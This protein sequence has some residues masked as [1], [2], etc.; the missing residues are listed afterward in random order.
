MFRCTFSLESVWIL[1]RF[2]VNNKV[3]Y[4]ELYR[5]C[6]FSLASPPT[7]LPLTI[8]KK[9]KN[10]S[11]KS[12]VFWTKQLHVGVEPSK[13]SQ[14][15]MGTTPQ[16]FHTIPTCTSCKDGVNVL[17]YHAIFF[18]IQF[19]YITYT[20]TYY[21]DSAL[22]VHST[23]SAYKTDHIYHLALVFVQKTF[24]WLVLIFTYDMYHMQILHTTSLVPRPHQRLQYRK[25]WRAWYL[26]SHEHYVYNWKIAKISEQTGCVARIVQLTTRSMLGVYD[27]H[28]LL[29]RYVR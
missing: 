11:N 19:H 7:S 6:I 22:L 25:V 8:P 26:F 15:K 9:K 5:P 13:T 21:T 27:N 12:Q 16:H 20:L 18:V 24:L 2:L 3:V 23:A 17:W 4:F 1:S 28:P 10:N 29:A 14:N